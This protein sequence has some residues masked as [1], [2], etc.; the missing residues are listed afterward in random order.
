MFGMLYNYSAVPREK[1]LQL[2]QQRIE[3]V[4]LPVSQ[5]DI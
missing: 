3:N 1:I 5:D 2:L 4:W